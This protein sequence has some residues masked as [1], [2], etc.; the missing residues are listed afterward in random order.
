MCV[1]FVFRLIDRFLLISV[2]RVTVISASR[3]V[4]PAQRQFGHIIFL[5]LS[6]LFLCDR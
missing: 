3:E 4:R 1:Y 6:V 2:Y 5:P